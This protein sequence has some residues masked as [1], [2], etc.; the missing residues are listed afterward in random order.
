MVPLD[1][2]RR[3]SHMARETFTIREAVARDADA[4]GRLHVRAWQ[5]AY[6]N[7]MP[8]EYLDGLDPDERSTMWRTRLTRNGL[9]PLL[10]GVI[11]D[12]VVGF[13]TFGQA[14]PPE[15]ATTGELYAMNVDPAH[16]GNGVGRALLRDSTVRLASIG[17]TDAILWVVPENARAR[18]LYESEGWT[19]DHATATEEIL[20]VTVTDM[21]LR[22]TLT[23]PALS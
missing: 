23:A 12:D 6:R 18:G 20:G 15:N 22:K 21:R 1:A 10:V 4:M 8:R 11:D 9:P 13:A 5:H 19:D 7:V 3:D 17:F 2:L 16:W 14:R